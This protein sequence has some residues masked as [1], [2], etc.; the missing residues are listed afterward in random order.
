MRGM[1]FPQLPDYYGGRP[2]VIPGRGGP[3]RCPG[4]RQLFVHRI[5]FGP[6]WDAARPSC[7][8]YTSEFLDLTA[9]GR[10]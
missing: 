5:M 2:P 4:S 9:F 1:P 10:Q 7:T 6:D 3:A 8:E